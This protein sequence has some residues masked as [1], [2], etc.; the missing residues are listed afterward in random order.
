[1]SDEKFDLRAFAKETYRVNVDKGFELSF[2]GLPDD[3]V[4][5]MK[6]GILGLV[7]SEIGEAMEE[8]RKGTP[9]LYLSNSLKPEG[10]A[11]ELADAVIRIL[12]FCEREGIDLIQAMQIKHNY[13]KNRSYKHGKLA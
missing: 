2:E 13:N 7:T 12:N 3:V 6:L 4:V 10:L 1:M 11:V 5:K 8:I 9:P